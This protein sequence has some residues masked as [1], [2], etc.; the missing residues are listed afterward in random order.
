MTIKGME[1]MTW[2]QLHD[3]LS[4]GGKFVVYQYCVSILI[5]TFL[6]SSDIYFV[7]AHEGSVGK[8][9]GFTCITLLCGWWGIPWGPIYTIMALCTNLG[10]GKNVTNEVLAT[11]QPRPY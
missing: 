1:G 5:L 7:R 3:E 8:G 6:Q 10:G 4:R 2:D 9:M 11:L